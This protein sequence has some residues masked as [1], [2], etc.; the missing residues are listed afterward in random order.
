[1]MS[2]TACNALIAS[3]QGATFNML[4]HTQRS[5][6][7][8]GPFELVP[9]ELLDL[10]IANLANDK[11][12]LLSC[13]VVHPS[14]TSI[15]RY[16][17]PPWTLILSSPFRAQ[18]LLTILRSSHETLSSTITGVTLVGDIPFINILSGKS[19][20]RTR[21]YRTLFQVLEAKHA[22]LHSGAVEYDSSLVGL[23]VEYFPA[24]TELKVTCASYQ[25]ITSFMRALAGSFPRL[26]ELSIELRSGEPDL[27]DASLSALRNLLLGVPFL[28]S[29]RVVGWNN[30]LMRWLGDNVAG[31][32]EYLE[33]ESVSISSTCHPGEA[34]LLLQRNQ[35]TLK[36]IRMTFLKRDVVFDISSLTHLE[37]L[38]FSGAL[39]T[40]VALY[41]WKLPRSLKRVLI[42]QVVRARI[43]EII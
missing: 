15:S 20:A 40:K 3:S 17:L 16:Y 14:W 29:L 32:L 42:R 7:S 28:R 12:A 22:A 10:T 4:A 19:R 6:A 34:D 8:S 31:T 13:A 18:E 36:D 11:A 35:T 1:M 33:L 38:E 23:F 21:S 30:D 5:S 2:A 41:G 26:L 27:P 9:Q 43:G 25:D 39:D 37:N 24:L